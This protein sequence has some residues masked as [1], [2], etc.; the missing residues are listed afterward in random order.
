MKSFKNIFYILATIGLIIVLLY[1]GKFLLIP[2]SFG[3]LIAILL[4]P[5]MEKLSNWI[6]YHSIKYGLAL[7]VFASGFFIPVYLIITSITGIFSKEDWSKN[8]DATIKGVEEEITTHPMIINLAPDQAND[9][10]NKF[11]G[12]LQDFI[13]FF[14]IDSMTALSNII[15]SLLFSYFLHAYYVKSKSTILKALEKEP[16]KTLKKITMLVPSAIQSYVLGLLLVMLVMTVLTSILFLIIGLD[17]ALLWGAIVG[18]FVIIPYI[19][20]IIG[21]AFP[22]MYSIIQTGNIDQA[23]Y[24]LLG[25]AV[26]QFLEGNFITP[27]IIGDKVGINPFLI[28]LVM[29]FMGTLWGIPGVII[30]IPLLTVVKTIL[31][32]NELD[33]VVKIF[34]NSK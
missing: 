3:A 1:Y 27:R 32:A 11:L 25:Y 31:E 26:I 30:S 19:G 18:F 29:L 22:L 10:L 16:R 34:F 23:L 9:L 7:T 20:S 33:S 2:L 13:G 12:Y 21:I 4:D 8:L 28:I 24:I 15:F 14:V 5:L 6:S 17:Y